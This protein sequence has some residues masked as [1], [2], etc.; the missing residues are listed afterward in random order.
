MSRALTC[1]ER[2]EEMKVL[3]FVRAYTDIE[4]GE[5][6]AVDCTSPQMVDRQISK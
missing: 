2:L 6:L 4:M 3:Y 1:S 5:R